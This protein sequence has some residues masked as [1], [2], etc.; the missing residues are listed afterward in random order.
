MDARSPPR[1]VTIEYLLP[2]HGG[3]IDT[4]TSKAK[5]AA[6]LPMLASCFASPQVAVLG[7]G[8]Q[9]QAVPA[10]PK[11]QLTAKDHRLWESLGEVAISDDG[12]A[13]RTYPTASL[14]SAAEA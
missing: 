1:D 14:Y 4:A 7:D 10:A 3:R 5:R 11:R 6:F 13:T 9:S 2:N 8:D 12:R